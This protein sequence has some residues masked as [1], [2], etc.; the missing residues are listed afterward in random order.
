MLDG[1][2]VNG[3][4]DGLRYHDETHQTQHHHSHGEETGVTLRTLTISRCSRAGLRGR[5]QLSV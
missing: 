2:F 1:T 3:F 4:G 5:H